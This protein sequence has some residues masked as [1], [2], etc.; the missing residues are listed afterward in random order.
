M[1]KGEGKH[2]TGAGRPVLW[3]E[4]IEQGGKQVGI[5]DTSEEPESG[6]GNIAKEQVSCHAHPD[7]EG[8]AKE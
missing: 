8:K 4:D 2:D 6:E 5:I 1:I 7:D 3:L